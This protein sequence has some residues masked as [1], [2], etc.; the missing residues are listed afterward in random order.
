MGYRLGLPR[1]LA[2][3]DKTSGRMYYNRY[4]PTALMDKT[5]EERRYDHYK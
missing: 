5:L 2:L 3:V 4:M 1:W